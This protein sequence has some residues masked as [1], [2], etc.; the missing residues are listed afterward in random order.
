MA[1]RAKLTRQ[2]QDAGASPRA[3]RAYFAEQARLKK[4]TAPSEPSGRDRQRAGL[5][6]GRATR[7]PQS[8]YDISEM[9]RVRK[10][11]GVIV[12]KEKP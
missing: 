10:P 12:W 1:D 9:A 2:M 7:H 6:R 5:A 8:P 3:I 11:G 4:E